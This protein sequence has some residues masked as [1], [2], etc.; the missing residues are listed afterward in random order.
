M[1]FVY[2]CRMSPVSAL[3][4]DR[5]PAA[6]EVTGPPVVLLHGFASTADGDWPPTRWAEP[7]SAGGRATLVVHLPGHEDETAVGS[8]DEVTTGRVLERIA[9]TVRT[10][11]GE[12]ID[13]I[14][15][16]LGARL[17]WDLVAVSPLPVRRLV[18]GGL[19]P[20]EPFGA[21]DLGA[22]RTFV[23][24]GPRPGDPITGIIAGMAA[25][26]GHDAAS[27]LNLVEGLAR[28][29]FDPSAKPPTVPTLLVAGDADPMAQGIEAVAERVPGAQLLRVPGDHVGALAGDDFRAAVFDFLGVDRDGR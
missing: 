15:Y 11:P 18:L 20:V 7:L 23:A 13:V 5:T 17:A 26:P 29:P 27:L 22:A 19:S 21:V 28:E 24:G 10:A 4:A 12:E 8:A 14:G 9:E 2:I 3:P 1:R 6:G 16:S 25:A